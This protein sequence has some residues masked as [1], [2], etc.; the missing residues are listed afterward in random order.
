MRPTYLARLQVARLLGAR[1]PSDIHERACD[2]GLPIP[3]GPE[4]RR[5]LAAVRDTGVIFIHVPKTAGMSISAALYGRQIRHASIRYYHRFAPE[6]AGRIP[7]FAILRDPVDR[8]LSAY[9]YAR[10]SGT[11]DNAVSRV[12]RSDYLAFRSPDDALDHVA[13]AQSPYAVDHIFR[14]QSW[15]VTDQSGQVAV[16]R[17]VPFDRL[18]DIRLPVLTGRLPHINRSRREPVRLRP[19]QLERIRSLYDRDVALFAAAHLAHAEFEGA[20]GMA[21]AHADRVRASAQPGPLRPLVAADTLP[22]GT[23]PTDAPSAG[24]APAV[25]S[26]GDRRRW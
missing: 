22:T 3:L 8:F 10:A 17:L 2:L 1:L 7:S 4:R 13:A 23:R 25:A 5:R 11:A 16:D 15:Y 26:P 19:D 24:H 18:A 6:M 12:F 14:P 21:F 9:H 20:A